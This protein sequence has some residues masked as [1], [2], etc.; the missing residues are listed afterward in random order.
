MI[1]WNKNLRKNDP[2][3]GPWNN[4]PRKNSIL[5]ILFNS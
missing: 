1:P 5:D 4:G 2:L 3:E